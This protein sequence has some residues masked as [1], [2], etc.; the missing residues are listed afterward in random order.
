[1]SEPE[2]EFTKAELHSALR[3]A[4]DTLPA[5]DRWIVHL[6]Y[7]TGRTSAEIGVTT[8]LTQST[9]KWRLLRS[10]EWLREELAPFG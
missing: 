1:M 8:G 6:S 10:K 5:D 7:V 3:E 2:G 9:V 4:L